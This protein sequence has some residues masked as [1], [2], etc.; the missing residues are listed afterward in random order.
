MSAT[1]LSLAEAEQ[2]VA[3][4][5][6]ASPR[7]AHSRFVGGLMRQL[8]GEL[9]ADTRL[10]QLAGLVHDLDYFAVDGDWSQHGVQTA[11]WLKDRLPD[12][13]L[14]AIAAH[15]HRTGLE[16]AMPI[17]DCLRLA[18]GL[19]V[20]DEDAGRD[21]TLAA[22]AGGSIADVV[23]RRTFLIEIIAGNAAKHGVRLA[24]LSNLLAGLPRQDQL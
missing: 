19:A 11:E 4:R 8:A 23:G 3:E 21:R 14:S 13:A 12:E 20:L 22:L 17:A 10:W 24:T 18:D 16:S 9:G 15:D 1:W 5:L 6:G 7:A 2:L